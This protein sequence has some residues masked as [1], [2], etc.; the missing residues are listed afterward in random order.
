MQHCLGARID[1]AYDGLKASGGGALLG[2]DCSRGC[3]AAQVK[4]GEVEE[5]RLCKPGAAGRG[6]QGAGRLEGRPL[7]L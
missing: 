2:A 3:P 4:R 7:R 5:R 6:S 1:E